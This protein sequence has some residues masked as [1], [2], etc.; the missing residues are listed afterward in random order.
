VHGRARGDPAR[1]AA[2][3]RRRRRH[4]TARSSRRSCSSS[5]LTSGTPASSPGRSRRS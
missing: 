4:P 3:A 2:Y 1:N 5:P